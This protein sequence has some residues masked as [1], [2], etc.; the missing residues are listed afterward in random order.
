MI[1]F[2]CIKKNY[3]SIGFFHLKPISLYL[4]YFR[5]HSKQVGVNYSYSFSPPLSMLNH[6]CSYIF[7]DNL[8]PLLWHTP[9]PISLYLF[10]STC[11]NHQSIVFFFIFPA[12]FVTP[13]LH[14]YSLIIQ[15]NLV[16]PY[17]YIIKIN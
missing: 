4:L 10:L 8:H 12:T 2:L 16:T 15:S 7:L 17:L 5:L 6:I 3:L 1:Q 13:K 14:I 9:F 11:P